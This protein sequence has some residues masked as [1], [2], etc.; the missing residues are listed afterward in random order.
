MIQIYSPTNTNY[1]KNGDMTLIP[2]EATVHP[3]LNGAWEATLSHPLDAE[4]RWKYIV[5]EAVVKMPSFNG[6]QLFRIKKKEKSDSGITATMEPIFMDAMGDCF[7]TDIRPTNATGQEALN[8]MTAPNS[9]YSGQSDILVTAT[10]YYQYKNL[11][12]ALN[13]GEDNCFLNRWGGEIIYN[14]FTVIVNQRAGGDYGVELRYGKNI[15]QDGMT[16]EVDFR[17]VI[18]RIYPK[19]F[20]GYTMSNDGYV[21]SPL[22]NNYPTVKATTITYSDVKMRVDVQEGD[23]DSGVIICDTQEQLNAALTAKC[24]AEFE[25]GIDK[26]AVSIS[27][28]MV[29]LQNTEQYKDYA[30]LETVSLGDTIHCINSHLDITTDARVIELEY[31]SIR[32]KVVSVVIGDYQYEY[33]NNV[34]SAAEKAESA[35]RNDGTVRADQIQGIINAQKANLRAMKDIAQTQEVRAVL[36]EDLDPNSPTFGAMCLGTMGF[37]IANE[38]TADGRDWQWSTFGTGDGFFADYIVA[39][40]MLADRIRG[41]TLEVGG[42]GLGKDGEIIIKDANDNILCI[43]NDIG[44]DVR[45]G[46]IIGTTMNLGGQNN[47]QGILTVNASDGTIAC[48][49]SGAGVDVRKG[50]ITGSVITLGGQN[51]QQGEMT[52]NN[53][54][55]SAAVKLDGTGLWAILGTIGGWTIASDILWSEVAMIASYEGT[56]H[57]NRATMNNA[58]FKIWIGGTE[59]CYLGRGGYNGRGNSNSGL[60]FVSGPGGSA[61]V[62]IDGSTGKVNAQGDVDAGGDMH[63]NGNIEAQGNVTGQNIESMASQIGSLSGDINGLDSRINSLASSISSLSSAVSSL[64]SRV[65]ALEDAS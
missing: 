39:G 11:I 37:Q 28:D 8:A 34:T 60:F 32:Q 19:A 50:T 59:R 5:D 47:Q 35:I 4:G 36:F 54:S 2:S 18:T 20:N 13:D 27:A 7:L 48:I 53:A 42:S 61:G 1:D 6:D 52:V 16:E 3:I 55:G 62:E 12:E 22:V 46:S 17:D 24:N 26:P 10:A 21:D 29:L 57:N 23:E 56:N 9:K 33:F 40:T 31:D 25:A 41:G 65:S 49:L 64:D 14:N 58:S 43:L 38:R 30:V 45:K 44:V 51:N 63:A 15:P